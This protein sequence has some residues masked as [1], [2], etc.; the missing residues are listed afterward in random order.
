MRSDTPQT[1]AAARKHRVM[2]V[3]RMPSMM[4]GI[5]EFDTRM[6]KL[7]EQRMP[8]MMFG[9]QTYYKE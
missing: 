2:S 8:T 3:E 4:L 1:E 9:D 5:N 7:E 6:A